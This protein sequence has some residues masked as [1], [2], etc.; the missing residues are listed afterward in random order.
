MPDLPLPLNATDITTLVQ[1]TFRLMD[2]LY[3]ER[4]GG[5]LLGDVFYIGNDDI[6]AVN[7]GDGLTKEGNV[8]AIDLSAT[9]GLTV[10]SGGLSVKPKT[11][12]GLTVDA[13]G[14]SFNGLYTGKVWD[15]ITATLYSTGWSNSVPSTKYSAVAGTLLVPEYHGKSAMHVEK[16][17]GFGAWQVS[18]SSNT[19]GTGAKTFAI[20][21]E[22]AP[23]V[24]GEPVYITTPDDASATMNGTFTSYTGTTVV[25]DVTSVTGSGTF[26]NWKLRSIPYEATGEF[27]IAKVSGESCIS[28]LRGMGIAAGGAGEVHGVHAH[29]ENLYTGAYTNL[30]IWGGFSL[31]YSPVSSTEMEVTGG[32]EVD[33]LNQHACDRLTNNWTHPISFGHLVM[34]GVAYDQ[35]FGYAVGQSAGKFNTGF[36]VAPTCITPGYEAM[37]INGGDSVPNEYTAIRVREHVTSALDTVGAVISAGAIRLGDLHYISMNEKNALYSNGASLVIGGGFDEIYVDAPLSIRDGFGMPAGAGAGKI[38][39]SDANGLGS[40]QAAVGGGTMSNLVEDLSP[41]LGAI[42]DLNSFYITNSH[43]TGDNYFYQFSANPGAGNHNILLVDGGTNGSGILRVQYQQTADYTIQ[44]EH[45][46]TDGW[47]NVGTGRLWLYAATGS[48]VSLNSQLDLYG[49]Y[50]T[51]DVADSGNYYLLFSAGADSS[52][53]NAIVASGGASGI[54]MLEAQ[55]NISATNIIQMYH[56]GTDGHITTLA[57]DLHLEPTGGDTYVTGTVRSDGT[58]YMAGFKMTTGAGAGKVL[59]SDADGDGTWETAASGGIDNVVED[60][61]PQLGGNLDMN[62]KFVVGYHDGDYNVIHAIGQD[63]SHIGAID[64]WYGTAMAQ[65]IGMYHNGSNGIIRTTDGPIEIN[66]GATGAVFVDGNKRIACGGGSTGSTTTPNGT[67]TLIINDVTYYLL[68]A[69]GA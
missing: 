66:P 46:G 43:K 4:I 20:S 28:G 41:E 5:A 3:S 9:G 38:L 2:D 52:H 1:Q 54:G 24:A 62:G 26:S 16:F 18:T 21:V 19:I 47:I 64:V 15:G 33:M 40:W 6:L 32:W 58:I 13:D 50:I 51:N 59:T 44:L 23:F 67:V 68:K 57:G 48:K 34:N 29:V 35:N 42:L 49:H 53:Y 65:G 56:N 22:T 8:L 12:G 31:V 39:T 36:M 10:S 63:A 7:V 17:S 45:N 60:T 27:V 55:H 37:Y 61:S 25:V 69:A 11:G 14:L 30:G